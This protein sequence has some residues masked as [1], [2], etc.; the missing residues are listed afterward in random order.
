MQ[1]CVDVLHDSEM[2]G[3]GGSRP[4]QAQTRFRCQSRAPGGKNTLASFVEIVAE[5]SGFAL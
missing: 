3:R 1:T 4:P 2:R 5:I